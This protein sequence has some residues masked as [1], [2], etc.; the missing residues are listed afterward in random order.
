M[1]V[2]RVET[3]SG[4]LEVRCHEPSGQEAP[5]VVVTVHPWAALGGGEH[6]TIGLARELSKR[7][8]IAL[9]F[10]MRS[11]SMVWGVLTKHAAEAS[12][13]LAVCEWAR[14]RWSKELVLLGSSAGAPIAGTVLPK[15]EAVSRFVAVGYPWGWLSSIGFGRHYNALR[16]CAKVRLRQLSPHASCIARY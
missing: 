2:H 6:N 7:G 5:F 10:D 15:L 8:A 16:A 9:S 11:S 13:L 4:S 1:S 12:Q 3:A 14:D